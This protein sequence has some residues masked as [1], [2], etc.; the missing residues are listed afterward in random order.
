MAFTRL[1][2]K[3]VIGKDIR[4]NAVAPGLFWTPLQ[5]S[6]GKD[7]NK[8][9]QFGATTG[10]PGQPAEIAALVRLASQ[11]SCDATG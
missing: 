10:G 3:Q 11:D 4:V 7:P 2:A 6:D 8:L 1:L 5:P 9:S